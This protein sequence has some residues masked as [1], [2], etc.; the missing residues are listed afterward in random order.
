MLISTA[1]VKKATAAQKAALSSTLAKGSKRRTNPTF[2]RPKT[3]TLPRT[4]AYPTRS[5]PKRHD[6]LDHHAV[7][8]APVSNES[9]TRCMEGQNTLVFTCDIR[10]NKK[11]IKAAIKSLYGL[12][13]Q[14]I[15]TL[16]AT[17]GTKKA[18]IRL[19]AEQDAV[20]A[21]GKI[22]CV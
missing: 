2:K 21:A 4:P 19:V 5:V 18:Y 9:A 15:N 1:A 22:G 17:D 8:R 3:L 6:S 13:A 14:R 7:L 16:I 12:D 10:A 20:E 11:M